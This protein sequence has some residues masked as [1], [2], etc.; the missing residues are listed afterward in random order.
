MAQHVLSLRVFFSV[1]KIV[2]IIMII[3]IIIIITSASAIWPLA[4]VFFIISSVALR[5]TA[6]SVPHSP[7]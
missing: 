2:M 3:A 4:V 5:P 6:G 7:K 1:I